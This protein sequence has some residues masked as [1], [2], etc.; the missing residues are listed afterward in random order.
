MTSP[1][2]QIIATDVS[3]FCGHTSRCIRRTFLYGSQGDSVLNSVSRAESWRPS[4]QPPP[5]EGWPGLHNRERMRAAA[6]APPYF[7]LGFRRCVSAQ[8]LAARPDN[9]PGRRS[10]SLRFE[11]GRCGR[12]PPSLGATFNVRCL[13][14]ER[15]PRVLIRPVC[16]DLV[17]GQRICAHIRTRR[18][19]PADAHRVVGSA[20]SRVDPRHHALW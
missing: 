4:P 12:T 10:R 1:S 18:S 11:P 5:F 13:S 8:I 16:V 17:D 3:G 2:Q 9:F 15:A 7:P 20:W 6:R 19:N 14:L